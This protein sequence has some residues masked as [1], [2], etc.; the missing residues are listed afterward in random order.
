MSL[1][2]QHRRGPPTEFNGSYGDI[3]SASMAYQSAADPFLGGLG[4]SRAVGAVGSGSA[5]K[6]RDLSDVS[7]SASIRSQDDT[8]RYT[9]TSL[10]FM[11]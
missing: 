11:L 6:N 5:R 3:F 9:A 1:S 10:S 8:A 4:G 7:D 2:L